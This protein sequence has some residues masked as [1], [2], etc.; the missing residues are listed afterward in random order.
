MGKQVSTSTVCIIGGDPLFFGQRGIHSFI[1]SFSSPVSVG[2]VEV[3][4]VNGLTVALP[5]QFPKHMLFSI[6][7]IFPTP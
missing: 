4:V 7:T 1:H 3:M 5:Y 6:T 2:I